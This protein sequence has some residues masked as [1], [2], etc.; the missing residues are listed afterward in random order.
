MRGKVQ[1]WG[2][3]LALRIP[4]AL[5]VESGL[6][7]GSEVEILFER[8]ELIVKPAVKRYVLEDL[9]AG[10]T[11]EKLHSSVETGAAVGDETW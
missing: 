1:R 11:P 2:N 7:A 10:I 8:G 4:K 6:G 3:S 5:A 9:L